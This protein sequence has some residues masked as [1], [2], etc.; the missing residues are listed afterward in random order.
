MHPG[1]FIG[2]TP[3]KSPMERGEKGVSFYEV[4]MVKDCENLLIRSLLFLRSPFPALPLFAL[5]S[6]G[7]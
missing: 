5:L 6:R 7:P 4:L 1:F 3:G 2:L